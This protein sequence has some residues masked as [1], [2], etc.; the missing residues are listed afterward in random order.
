[1]VFPACL[2]NPGGQKRVHN[3]AQNAYQWL[4]RAIESHPYR[5]ATPQCRA[6]AQEWRPVYEHSYPST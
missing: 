4:S 5:R 3:H 1:M 6:T 2:Q